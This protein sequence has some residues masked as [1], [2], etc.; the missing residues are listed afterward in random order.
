MPKG[1]QANSDGCF[2]QFMVV[3]DLNFNLCISGLKTDL[4]INSEAN[5]DYI[6]K[7]NTSIARLKA[8]QSESAEAISDHSQ[9]IDELSRYVDK[10]ENKL[11][12]DR[13]RHSRESSSDS[14]IK[15]VALGGLS[16]YAL[17]RLIHSV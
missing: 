7:L 5:A 8:D 3:H 15:D 10:L 13:E 6:G 1:S 9:H 11:L 17:G 16:G 12:S 4:K 14:L 2:N